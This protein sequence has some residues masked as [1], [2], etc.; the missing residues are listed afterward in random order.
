MDSGELTDMENTGVL[1]Y[2][3]KF[4]SKE[5]RQKYWGYFV[6]GM[7]RGRKVRV[8]LVST[9][10]GGYDL[11]DIVFNGA[12]SVELWRKPY[13][14]KDEKG[15]ITASGFTYSVVSLDEDETVYTAQ[16]KPSRKSDKALL[17]KI[18]EL[19]M[20]SIAREEE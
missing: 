12:D 5:R 17:E 9:D 18:I 7:L 11:L 1:V 13:S 8:S 2:R 3:E 4:I 6:V 19:S 16:V 20:R 15:K 14:M 10:A